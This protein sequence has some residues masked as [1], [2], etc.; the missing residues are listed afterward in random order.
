MDVVHGQEYVCIVSV[1]KVWPG[2]RPEDAF[3]CVCGEVPE[4]RGIMGGKARQR[5]QISGRW[6]GADEAQP[7][8]KGSPSGKGVG[9]TPKASRSLRPVLYVKSEGPGR[10]GEGGCEEVRKFRLR[11]W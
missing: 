2:S 11:R 1:A 10:R 4:R 9:H 6:L 7:I 8:E 3:L 5:V